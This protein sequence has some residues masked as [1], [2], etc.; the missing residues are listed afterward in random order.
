MPTKT[1]KLNVEGWW[2]ALARMQTLGWTALTAAER[3]AL[4]E[5]PSR[6][7]VLLQI[8][9]ITNIL[10]DAHVLELNE[11]LKALEQ[12]N[13]L[14]YCGVFRTGCYY[15][16]HDCVTHQGSLWIASEGTAEKPGDG[17]TPW[18]LAVKRG[19]V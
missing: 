3:A 18:R 1:Q 14:S 10:R 15:E 2:R 4:A 9:A 16:K 12:R 19:S 8:E 11:R 13:T 17:A 5:P 6:R 7:E